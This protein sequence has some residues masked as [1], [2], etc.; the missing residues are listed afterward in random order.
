MIEVTGDLWTYPADA[1]VITTN[2]DVNSKGEAVMG[3]GCALECKTKYPWVPIMLGGQLKAYGNAPYVLEPRKDSTM[4]LR[5]MGA[6]ITFPVKHHWHQRAD[7][8]LIEKSAR[9]V[10]QMVDHLEY[11]TVVMPRPG[12]GNGKLDWA[13]VREVL[14]PI[15]DDRFH[16]ITHA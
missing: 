4:L 9:L 11:R 15:L 10:V 12:C 13:V 6:I 14:A 3:R 2:G 1:R 8:V 16:V 7:T 5:D